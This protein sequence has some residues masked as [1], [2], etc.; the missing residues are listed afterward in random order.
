M[1]WDRLLEDHSGAVLQALL[2]VKETGGL[3]SSLRDLGYKPHEIKSL[4][5]YAMHVG[6]RTVIVWQPGK[7]PSYAGT[8]EGAPY[9]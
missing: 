9:K 2:H 7:V 3:P 1:A 5:S 4:H 8:R 6:Y